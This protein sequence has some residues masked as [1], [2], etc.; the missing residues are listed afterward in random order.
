MVDDP[1][2]NMKF[3]LTYQHSQ[4]NVY[5]FRML[6][7]SGVLVLAS[8]TFVALKPISYICN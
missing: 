2:T 7:L 8:S 1:K 4:N 5:L 6:V 3:M